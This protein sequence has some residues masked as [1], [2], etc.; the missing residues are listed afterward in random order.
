M[1]GKVR[2]GGRLGALAASGGDVYVPVRD[3][4]AAHRGGT[5][6]VVGEKNAVDSADPAVAYMPI[7]WA[8]A[9][10]TGDGLVGYR[11]VGGTAG[12]ELVPDLAERMP[13]VSD[14]GRT[15]A[16]RLRR[17]VLYSTGEP[18]RA[19]DIRRGI[20][21]SFDI[22]N[23]I[24]PQYLGAIAGASECTRA[25]GPC[26]L[27]EGIVV[28]DR[29]RT[30]TIHLARRDPDLL[31]KLA[32]P[33]AFA[34]PASAPRREV[35]AGLPATGPYRFARFDPKREVLLVRNPHFREWSS[36]AQPAG[37]PDRIRVR[38]G[39]S[40]QAQLA[41]IRDGRADLAGDKYAFTDAMLRRLTVAY[42]S[43]LRFEP[44]FALDWAFLDTRSAPFRDERARRAV[45][46]AVDRSAF[47][48]AV[49]ARPT[50]QVL[51]PNSLGYR[52]YCPF[53][54]EG[55][56]PRARRL[57][58]RSRT[59]GATVR[60]W[61]PA[62]GTAAARM[63]LVV[64]ALRR[65]G[66]RTTVRSFKTY[67]AYFTALASGGRPHVGY[68][69]WFADYPAPS[70]VVGP[71]LSCGGAANYGGFCDRR[72]DALAQRASALQTDE[73]RAASDRWAEVDRRLTDA[74]AIVPL[75]TSIEVT[76]VSE[77]LQNVD[78]GGLSQLWV[79]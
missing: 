45:N 3:S 67:G 32:L 11:R 48:G 21:R 71:L 28:D 27:S 64:T 61:S 54:L 68:F 59:R 56:L 43:R 26:D 51:P 18:V 69:P 5:V 60:V 31:N 2:L 9:P 7:T 66:Y 63:R 38:L 20:E 23:S 47:A 35:R 8:L 10:I 57:V 15:L 70:A 53:G 78:A 65:L 73:P 25:G 40:P 77:R 22:P 14:R 72:I 75:T 1:E 33:P 44:N 49:N 52:S 58:A 4:G 39:L 37:Y 6:E 55:D 79:R 34:V 50:C 30:L 16:F 12:N 41:A 13:A 19:S 46:F 76:F 36:A 42:A 29:S 62:T 24:G 74:A 17:G